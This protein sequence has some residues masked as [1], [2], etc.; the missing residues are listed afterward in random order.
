MKKTIFPPGFIF[1][2]IL[3]LLPTCAAYAGI[4]G[5]D[6]SCV[7]ICGTEWASCRGSCNKNCK[8]DCASDPLNYSSCVSDCLTGNE[9]CEGQ[10]T[11]DNDTCIEICPD[12]Q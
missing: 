3:L 1:G 11:M 8:V 7:G 5:K 4:S 10:C 2:I 12:K 9:W 6:S